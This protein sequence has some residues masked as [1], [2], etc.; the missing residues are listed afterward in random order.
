MRTFLIIL[1]LLKDFPQIKE[2]KKK[3]FEEKFPEEKPEKVPIKSVKR[4]PEK[5]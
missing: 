2:F 5:I 3:K 4:N 1:D